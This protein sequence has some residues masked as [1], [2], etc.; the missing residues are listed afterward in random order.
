[1]NTVSIS[2]FVEYISISH[3]NESPN[4]IYAYILATSFDWIVAHSIPHVIKLTFLKYIVS[5]FH[6]FTLANCVLHS[7]LCVQFHHI[8]RMGNKDLKDGKWEIHGK[9][10]YILLFLFEEFHLILIVFERH[11]HNDIFSPSSKSALHCRS[12][13]PVCV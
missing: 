8:G 9:F 2:N 3:F 5:T 7:I 6:C 13:A 4:A 10:W 12:V 11:L 1:M